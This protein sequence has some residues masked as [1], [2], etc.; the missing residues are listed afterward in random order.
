MM[1]QHKLKKKIEKSPNIKR[2]LESGANE[3][4]CKLVSM[5]YL[6]HSIANSLTD[7]ANEVMGKYGLYHFEIKYHGNNLVKAFDCYNRAI[8]KLIIDEESRWEFVRDF[9]AFEKICRD[10]MN[11]DKEKT[12][13]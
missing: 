9:E 2:F 1:P 11:L 6:L 13:E 5:A 8:T 4:A 10:F 3:K 12:E 7:E